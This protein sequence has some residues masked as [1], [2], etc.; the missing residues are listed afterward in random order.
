M[1]SYFN[2]KF[3]NF[4]ME[5][6]GQEMDLAMSFLRSEMDGGEEGAGCPEPQDEKSPE[7]LREQDRFLPIANVARIMK[8]S[9]PR[10][11]KV[12]LQS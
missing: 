4:I 6:S 8:K 2:F 5:S 9:I 1:N 3:Q 12:L 7:V 11:G 10:T